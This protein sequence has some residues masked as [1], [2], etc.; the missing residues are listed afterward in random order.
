MPQT[1]FRKLHRNIAPILFLPLLIGSL[2]GI[3][4][5]LGRSWFGMTSEQA[6][7]F[8]VLHQGD[9]L[10]SFLKPIY[11]RLVG[12]GLAVMLFSGIR[13]SGTFTRDRLCLNSAI[14][15]IDCRQYRHYGSRRE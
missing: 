9:Y 11:V 1:N 10:G 2:T 7:I 14:A 12:V 13:I 3:A 5:R 15:A 4:Y 6:E 8:L